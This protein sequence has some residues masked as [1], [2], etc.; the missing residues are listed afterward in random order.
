MY[1]RSK[2]KRLTMNK[3]VIRRANLKP[4]LHGFDSCLNLTHL[5]FPWSFC[6]VGGSHPVKYL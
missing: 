2:H 6:E 3:Y 4:R 5:F 1:F